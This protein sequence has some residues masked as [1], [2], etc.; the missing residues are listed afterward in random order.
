MGLSKEGHVLAYVAE[1]AR[2]PPMALAAPV[3]RTPVRMWGELGWIPSEVPSAPLFHTG[4]C[5]KT[6][7]RGDLLRALPTHSPPL[8]TLTSA[9]LRISFFTDRALHSR[10]SL[11]VLVP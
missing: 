2:R 7:F 4:V 1:K 3:L 5:M 9:F 6:A 11:S 8:S 10:C